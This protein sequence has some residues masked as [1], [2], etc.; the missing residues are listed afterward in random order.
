MDYALYDYRWEGYN[1]IE[2]YARR[3][4]I[5]DGSDERIILDAMLKPRFS[6]FRVDEIMKGFG[7]NVLDL[8]RGD[9]SFIMDVAWSKSAIKGSVLACR[10]I[11]PHEGFSMSTGAGLPVDRK[12][13]R[14]ITS[15]ISQRFGTTG[16]ENSPDV[17]Q[18]GNR[19]FHINYQNSP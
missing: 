9:K 8:F 10:V 18:E 15:E 13:L 16:S 12:I 3:T 6:L 4:S 5:Q 11:S 19:V 1:V 14:R 2:R 17:S 7:V